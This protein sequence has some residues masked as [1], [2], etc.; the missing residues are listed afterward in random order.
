MTGSPPPTGPGSSPST[1]RRSPSRSR[2]RG[3]RR[4]RRP[5]KILLDTPLSGT[6]AQAVNRDLV[7]YA[8]GDSAAIA[9]LGDVFEGFSRAQYD[10]GAFGNGSRMKFVANLL[11]AIHNVAT[12][13]AF[14]LGLKAGLEPETVFEVIS[15]SAANSRIFELRAPQ[16]VANDYSNASATIDMFRKDLES[17]RRLR[18]RNRLRHP[19]LR[20]LGPALQRGLGPGPRNRRRGQ[21]LRRAGAAGRGGAVGGKHSRSVVAPHAGSPFLV[22]RPRRSG[23][24][25]SSGHV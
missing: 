13:E 17:H 14:A 15:N 8:S 22:S 19:P 4:W 3:G 18:R 24:A 12:G 9:S 11:V 10:L 23:A 25:D 21:R 7:V 6:G 5:A 16:M 1:P 20:R 2:R